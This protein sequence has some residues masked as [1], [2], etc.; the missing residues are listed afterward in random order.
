M[1][2]TLVTALA[3][4]SAPSA[5][6]PDPPEPNPDPFVSAGSTYLLVEGGYGS[7]F[8]GSGR[9][10]GIGSVGLERFLWDGI[11]LG[12]AANGL[13]MDQPAG[14]TS[15]ASLQVVGRWYPTLG[16]SLTPYFHAGSGGIVTGE[17]VPNRGTRYN[18]S[19][20]LGVGV[21]TGIADSARLTLG[22]R[23]NHISNASLGDNNP[24]RDFI[25]GYAGLAV[26]L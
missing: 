20:D 6:D 2:S 8:Q 7:S 11:S 26:G 23:W 3:L 9:K 25:Y 24:G 1:I 5:S 14:D 4:L 16:R 22:A 17:P 18:F 10:L 12:V 21:S 13:W 15:G 19:S